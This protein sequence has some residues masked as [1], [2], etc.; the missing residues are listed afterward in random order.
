LAERRWHVVATDISSVALGSVVKHAR[1]TDPAA[2]ARIEWRH[3]DLLVSPPEHD[4]FDL[5][6][7]Q[8]V[9]LPPEARHRLF[10]ALQVSVRAGGALLLVGHHP[11]DMASGVH[12]PPQPD[13]FYTADDIA[14]LLDA[15]WTIV[16]HEARPRAASGAE[17]SM[18]DSVLLAVRQQASRPETGLQPGQPPGQTDPNRGAGTATDANHDRT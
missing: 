17:V 1:T 3:V 6:S 2:S 10:T 5:V 14:G 16:A 15:S 18:H 8:F 4:S 11:S 7:A 13:R 9:Q 12:R